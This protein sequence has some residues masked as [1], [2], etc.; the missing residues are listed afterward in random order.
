MQLFI[1]ATSRNPNRWEYLPREHKECEPEQLFKFAIHSRNLS[2]NDLRVWEVNPTNELQEL[3]KLDVTGNEHWLHSEQLLQLSNLTTVDGVHLSQYCQECS[4]CKRMTDDI[5]SSCSRDPWLSS[6][7]D[8]E[9]HDEIQYGRAL[10]FIKLGFWP[11]CLADNV[12]MVDQ[13]LLPF[14]I[15]VYDVTRKA[16]FALYVTGSAALLVNIAVVVFLVVHKS[17]RNDLAVRLLLNVAVC[18]ALIALVINIYTRFNFVEMYME[19]LLDELQGN[20]YGYDAFTKKWMKLV[21]IIGPI[22]TCAVAS[23]VFGSGISML[24]KFL[25]I[26]FAM[27]PDARLERKTAVVLLVFSWSISATF[28]VLPVFG[29]GEMTYTDWFDSIPL[30]VDGRRIDDEGRWKHTVGFAAGSQIALVILQLASFLLYVPIFIV[31]KKSAANVGMKRETAIAR[32]IALLICTNII[33]FTAPVVIGVFQGA[34]LM[35]LLNDTND[36]WRSRTLAKV[37][38]TLFLLQVF[39][40]LCFSINSLLNPFL[41]ALRHPNLKQQLNPLLCRCW[42]A[43]RE[44]FGTQRQNLRCHTGNEESINAREVEMQEGRIPQDASLPEEGNDEVQSQTNSSQVSRLRQWTISNE[45][46]SEDARL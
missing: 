21:N 14:C 26:V 19:H 3:K 28:A 34:V 37:Q 8:W 23:H 1:L 10:D 24:D 5:N 13:V 2:F 18:D 4:L 11:R 41:Y 43:T 33:F 22:L 36:D 35:N 6:P 7:H 32:K 9:W 31:A 29:I 38:W 40:V 16:F 12:C 30:P 27:K 42:A 25:K 46:G 17:L 39:P 45:Q 20:D 44:C 15:S